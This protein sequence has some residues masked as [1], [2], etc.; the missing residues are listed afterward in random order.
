M[1]NRESVKQRLSRPDQG[2]SFTEFSYSLLQSFDF[3]HL[4]Q[5]YLCKLQ[6][7]GNDQWGNIVSGIDLTRRLNN[8]VVHGLT[9]PL[10]TK[11]D[12]T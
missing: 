6:I 7:G 9:L 8:Q 1:I 3:A 4:N 12:G 10:I 2:I 11:S 5:Q